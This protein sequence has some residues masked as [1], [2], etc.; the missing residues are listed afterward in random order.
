MHS[1]IDIDGI[2]VIFPFPSAYPEQLEY[3]R[4]I[5]L[6][7][8]ATGP[9]L[10][11][12]PSG[13]GKTVCLLSMIIAYMSQRENAG[14]L[15][16]C[17][18]TIPELNQ[19]VKELRHVHQTRLEHSGIDYD[20]NFLGIALSCRANLCI[21]P[22]VA[23][24]GV[25]YDVDVACRAH[26]VQYATEDRCQFYDHVLMRPRP[27]VY[28]IDELKAFGRHNGL[29]PY[30]LARRLI[31]EA[32]V[33]M[34]SFA[35]TLDPLARE[36]LIPSLGK[37]AIVVYDEAHNIDDVCCE[38]MSSALS[39]ET[40]NKA[41]RSLKEA[42]DMAK[43]MRE[44]EQEKLSG[45][46]KHLKENLENEEGQMAADATMEIF[47]NPQL[48]EHILKC[49]MPATLRNFSDFLAT[50]K[51]VI[52]YFAGFIQG[53]EKPE[54]DG[55]ERGVI[56]QQERQVF[57]LD[58]DMME[59]VLNI[60]PSGNQYT[61][62]QILTDIKKKTEITPEILHFMY[63][64][65]G[66]FLSKYKVADLKMYTAL[67]DVLSFASLLATYDEGYLVFTENTPK[68]LLIQLVCVNPA[69]AFGSAL[70]L[71]KR[72]IVTSGTL[73]PPQIYP[74][75]LRFEPVT[76]QDFTMSLSRDCLLPLFVTRGNSGVPLSSAFK[77][78]SDPRVAKNYGDLLLN[79]AKIV[80]DG[81]VCFF[82]SYVYMNQL[83]DSWISDH[84]VDEV[85]KYK[86]IFMETEV[87][88]ESAMA[89]ENY[90]K[91]IESGRGAVFLGVARGRVSE[92][93][94]FAHHYGRCVL[95]FGLPVRN[96]QSQIVQ[97]RADYVES[98]LGMPKDEF[99][100]FDA[101][102]AAAQCV[103]RLLRSKTDYGIVVLADRRYARPEARSQLPHWIRQFITDGVL[104][105]TVERAIE[106]SR[107]FL[108]RMAQPFQHDPANLINMKR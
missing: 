76:I 27:G 2:E 87:A 28:G 31:S 16:Y 22:Q 99:M 105:V 70:Q 82:P 33:V 61:T 79:F 93:V 32:Q 24:I 9:A 10:L 34:C 40:L 74:R 54:G 88:A 83:L 18:R 6:S 11:E 72:V 36:L 21:F 50:A 92:G 15:I 4:Q 55:A 95:L 65:F 39:A 56:H 94:D 42:E 35:Y 30:F 64:R 108:V 53:I 103:G 51:D 45:V 44:E 26:T 77:L 7:L 84:V 73:S 37:Q 49:A 57:I 68:G 101:M 25:K 90:M 85:M 62:P 38:F 41:M 23:D 80:P 86:L 104:N 71:F 89:L 81:I 59:E 19:G 1:T 8:D 98:S 60:V 47:A 97:T 20:K 63:S 58:D 69:L 107:K 14:P 91:A 48:P 43:T 29:C 100:L 46:L 17:T 96:T 66:K 106:L 52:A 78:R 102:R 3:M 67:L 13:T 5:K 75:L 12:M